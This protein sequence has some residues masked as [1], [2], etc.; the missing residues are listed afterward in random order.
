MGAASMSYSDE[1]TSPLLT[2]LRNDEI[3]INFN[4]HHGEGTSFV[5]FSQT[6]Y[7][8]YES[9][10]S[11]RGEVPDFVI[12][13]NNNMFFGS[14][15]LLL[16]EST[17]RL[18][19]IQI[20]F[21]DDIE[22]SPYGN[23]CKGIKTS[24][25]AI[26]N[27]ETCSE[28]GE[29]I[30]AYF[31]GESI[32]FGDEHA[33]TTETPTICENAGGIKDYD[34]EIDVPSGVLVFANDMRDILPEIPARISVNYNIGIKHVVEDT[35]AVGALTA[36]VGNTCPGVYQNDGVIRV[37]NEGMD[38]DENV[39]DSLGNNLGSICTDLWW[40]YA[41]DKDDYNKRADGKDTRCVIEA[42]AI[43]PPGRYRMTVHPREGLDDGDFSKSDVYVTIQMVTND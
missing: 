17:D 5:P 27:Y 16:L 12:S 6:K 43:V 13:Q 11:E 9:S 2:K 29:R 21:G 41:M 20:A 1:F 30:R 10:W 37:G 33:F 32:Q 39:I 3:Q 8:K 25:I 4:G 35:C 31:N 14:I 18:S 42:E 40:F 26:T 23:W 15:Q 24:Y 7:A 36:F 38:D 28:C 22:E 19:T 34:V